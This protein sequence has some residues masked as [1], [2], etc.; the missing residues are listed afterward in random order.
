[1]LGAAI[2]AVSCTTEPQE[3]VE[4]DRPEAAK[5]VAG[6]QDDM[7]SGKIVIKFTDAVADR[8]YRSRGPNG[9]VS[10]TGMQRIDAAAASIG[11]VEMKPIFK[12]GGEFEERHREAGLHLWYVLSFDES[13][14]PMSAV[15]QF[16][17]LDGIQ[18]VKPSYRV[19][20]PEQE[21]A[22]PMLPSSVTRATTTAVN[23]PFND[24]M[25]PLQWHYDNPGDEPWSKE[26]AD[27]NLFDAWQ[28]TTGRPEVIVA[29]IDDGV[30]GDHEDLNQNM[31]TDANG[32]YG[33]NYTDET[34][35]GIVT[36]SDHGTHVAGTIA[37]VNNNG[38]GVGGIAGGDGSPNSGVRIM[39]CQ[40]FDGNF[41]VY[42]HLIADAFRYAA[43]NG[44]VIANCS[45]SGMVPI[46]EQLAGIQYFMN[47]AGRDRH[48]IQVG[49]LNG[50]VV[51]AA[52]GNGRDSQPHYPA[53]YD[54][55]ISVASIG[56]A[57][58]KA[59]YSCFGTTINVSAPGGDG[60]EQNIYPERSVL[61]TTPGDTYSWF[62]GTSMAAPHVTG[63]AALLASRLV[64]L[65][66]Q[67]NGTLEMNEVLTTA[68]NA[69][70]LYYHN[71]DM[72]YYMGMGA[73]L[74]N[75]AGAV[76]YANMPLS[77][78]GPAE[79]TPGTTER[80]T[81][82]TPLMSFPIN[83]SWSIVADHATIVS[84]N[85][86]SATVAFGGRE[87]VQLKVRISSSMGTVEYDYFIA[88]EGYT[89]LEDITLTAVND[90][91]NAGTMWHV[92]EYGY[93]T[94]SGIQN[95]IP[96]VFEGIEWKDGFG[97]KGW[98]HISPETIVFRVTAC[99]DSTGIIQSPPSRYV[100]TVGCTILYHSLH[101]T[102]ERLEKTLILP[103]E[104]NVPYLL[105]STTIYHA[106]QPF[107][108]SLEAVTGTNYAWSVPVYPPNY[109]SPDVPYAF[110]PIV[111]TLPN[112][113]TYTNPNKKR[114]VPKI[115]GLYV[116][117]ISPIGSNTPIAELS[118][119]VWP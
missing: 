96:G 55:V 80:Y 38:I 100:A 12:V 34:G 56:P 95:I 75:A 76:N 79:T 73:G 52:A 20:M 111:E 72:Q 93:L 105:P 86:Y 10:S 89:G 82:P 61:S 32:K 1:M 107:T 67:G 99:M 114:F 62:Q 118:L 17:G 47:F 36:P 71:P 54:G 22:T 29:V 113:L 15:E 27:I 24:P 81:F 74:I 97:T 58:Q 48:G 43:D 28:T 70:S 14:T 101:G 18:I 68:V 94:V 85:N 108:I 51:I 66:V 115:S 57:Y 116:I 64:D 88:C 92:N 33:F 40:I 103:V 2:F 78:S 117:Q 112:G 46:P 60:D 45:W 16:Q 106:N 98:Q 4:P 39:S 53:A 42:D 19:R 13:I 69:S 5:I 26:G 8:M 87:T 90:T 41:V 102:I 7:A 9:T 63:V 11:T 83:V 59:F 21:I 31:W 77:I 50:G 35:L 37:A 23:Y 109:L 110:S 6:G 25:L 3:L 44:A 91:P 119:Q 84:S 65:N 30:D 104:N 49:P